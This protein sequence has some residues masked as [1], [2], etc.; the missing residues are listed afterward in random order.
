MLGIYENFPQNIHNIADFEFSV[1]VKRLQQTLVRT[2]YNLNNQSINLEDIT[3]PSIPNCTV[4]FELG[5]AADNG[6]SFLDNEE[7]DKLLK[8]IRRRPFQ[9]LDFLCAIRYNKTEQQK[10][11]RLKFDYYILRFKFA[12]QLLQMQICHERGPMHVS[13]KDLPEL[14]ASKINGD[15]TKKMLKP[16]NTGQYASN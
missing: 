2:I 4:V 7:R 10:R 14:F 8:T 3:L 9:T 6:F 11:I 16:I 5:I 13:H 12:A 1:S 15:F